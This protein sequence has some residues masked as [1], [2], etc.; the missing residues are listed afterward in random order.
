MAGVTSDLLLATLAT[1]SAIRPNQAQVGS[2]PPRPM[3]LGWKCE[4]GTVTRRPRSKGPERAI[5]EIEGHRTYRPQCVRKR[6]D[7]ILVL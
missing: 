1:S 4:V 7:P 3:G 2:A 6:K 5:D